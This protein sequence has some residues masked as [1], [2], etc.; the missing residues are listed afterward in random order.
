MGMNMSN[1]KHVF[2]SGNHQIALV[3]KETYHVGV[4]VSAFSCIT[5]RE[6]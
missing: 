4:R 2:G 6:C 1:L 3:G 5:D